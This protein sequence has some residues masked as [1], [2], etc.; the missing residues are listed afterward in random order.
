MTNDA[1]QRNRGHSMRRLPLALAVCA[2]LAPGARA[3][4]LRFFDDAPLHA[5]QFVDTREGWAV[6]DDGV[7]LHTINGGETWERQPT[8]VRASLRSLHFLSSL[9]GWVVGREDLPHGGGSVGV[10]LYTRD[11]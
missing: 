10:L 7:V 1:Q 6:G 5:I 2:V 9:I 3:A 8:G 4:D 11:G